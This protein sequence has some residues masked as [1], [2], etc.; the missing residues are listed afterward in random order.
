M[1]HFAFAFTLNW[2][3]KS[4]VSIAEAVVRAVCTGEDGEEGCGA[5][6]EPAQVRE[7]RG[8]GQ[9]DVP[10]RGVR[11]AQPPLSILLGIHLRTSVTLAYLSYSPV[12][13]LP[14]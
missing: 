9:H 13:Y 12:S 8:H 5:A 7:D 2:D 6:D 14:E 10:Q 1:A 11:V 3:T 4:F